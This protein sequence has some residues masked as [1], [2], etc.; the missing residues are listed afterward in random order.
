[1]KSS[2]NQ[3]TF[4]YETDDGSYRQESRNSDGSY[5]IEFGKTTDEFGRRKVVKSRTENL[6]ENDDEV[7]EIEKKSN[8]SYIVELVLITHLRIRSQRKKRLL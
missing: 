1:M 6:P 2:G 8:V 3:V 5:R 7:R 4:S